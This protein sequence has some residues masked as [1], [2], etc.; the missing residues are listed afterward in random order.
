MIY[1]NEAMAICTALNEFNLPRAIGH[2]SQDCFIAWNEKF[3]SG[4]GFSSEE[5]ERASFTELTTLDEV[6]TVMSGEDPAALSLLHFRFKCHDN[7]R[8][9][10]G[11][12]AIKDDQFVLLL[13]D[14]TESAGAIESAWQQGQ[15]DERDRILRLFHDEVG[16]KLLA[17]VFTAQIAKEE[18][19]AK[20]LKESETVAKVGDKLVEA[21]EGVVAVLDPEKPAQPKN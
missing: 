13:V 16:P 2:L 12:A 9:L 20:G 6:S 21:I 15:T 3:L 14:P 1:S 19:K 18:L 4:S 5:L 8:I 17:A 7:V 11:H 10:S